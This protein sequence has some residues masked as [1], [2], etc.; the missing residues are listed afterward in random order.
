MTTTPQRYEATTIES[1]KALAEFMIDHLDLNVSLYPSTMNIVAAPIT[2]TDSLRD[3]EAFIESEELSVLTYSI[4]VDKE[5]IMELLTAPTPTAPDVLK[6]AFSEL[7][8]EAR[9][10]KFSEKYFKESWHK[11]NKV[12]KQLKGA[13]SMLAE[14]LTAEDD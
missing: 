12:N 9:D 5:N 14:V 4:K 8:K 6:T 13:I 3:V 10:T 2:E 11:A 7:S 1:Y